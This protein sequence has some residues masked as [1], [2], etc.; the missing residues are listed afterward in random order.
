M[1]KKQLLL[2]FVCILLLS[3]DIYAQY[4]ENHTTKNNIKFTLLSLGSGST[5]I[6][7]E[8][9]FTPKHSAELTV[10]IIG[11]GW[12]WLHHTNSK[13]GLIKAAFKWNLIPQK[14]ANTWLAG[15]YVKPEFVAAF[16]DYAPANAGAD[17][18]TKHTNQFALLGECGYQVIVKWFVF[19]VYAGTG[20]SFGT[21]NDYNYYH[22]FML[23]P[24]NWPL[25][26]TA[27]FRLGVDF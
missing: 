7:Y 10:G 1:I 25:A 5:R 27:G 20:L 18:V 14:N 6:T 3:S 24:K 17:A 11:L 22:S 19:D 21:G 13:G 16:F 12:D 9:A 15:F 8:R 2:L 26:F 23:F 4:Y